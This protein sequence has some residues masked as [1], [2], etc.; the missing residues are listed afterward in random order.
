MVLVAAAPV[1]LYQWREGRRGIATD[2]SLR[3]LVPVALLVV[4]GVALLLA[5][6]AARFGDPFEAWMSYEDMHA[7]SARTSSATDSSTS[8]TSPQPARAAARD[9]GRDRPLPFATFSPHGL[10]IF[11]ATPPFYLY[12]LR[13]LRRETRR[14]AAIS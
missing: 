6:D 14:Q 11:L 8:T 1:G 9:A 10:S 4:A 12:L 3:R 5:F 2:A 7:C 13:S